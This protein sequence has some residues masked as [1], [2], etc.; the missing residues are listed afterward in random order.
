MPKLK[1]LQ[2]VENLE[3]LTTLKFCKNFNQFDYVKKIPYFCAHFFR[4]TVK[5]KKWINCL[6][7]LFH[8]YPPVTRKWQWRYM[9]DESAPT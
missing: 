9:L 8:L 4:H 1:T 2:Y 5:Q 3:A 7:V 6:F